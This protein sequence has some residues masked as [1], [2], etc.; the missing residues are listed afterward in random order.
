MDGGGSVSSCRFFGLEISNHL[1]K[2]AGPPSADL[3]PPVFERKEKMAESEKC[4]KTSFYA[5]RSS[6]RL[7][8]PSTTPTMTNRYF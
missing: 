5:T 4:V 2:S 3:S 7:V 8:T 6:G 1:R